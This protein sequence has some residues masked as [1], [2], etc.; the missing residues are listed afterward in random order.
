[1]KE[2]MKTWLLTCAL[3]APLILAIGG[4]IANI[5]KLVEA[6]SD[7]ITAFFIARIVGIFFAPLGVILGYL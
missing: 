7:P 5:V 2:N 3:A 6:A 4:W 1:M